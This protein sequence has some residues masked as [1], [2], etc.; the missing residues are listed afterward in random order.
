MEREEGMVVDGEGRE[1]ERKWR[2]SAKEKPTEEVMEGLPTEIRAQFERPIDVENM[3]EEGFGFAMPMRRR[4]E[5][6]AEGGSGDAGAAGAGGRAIGATATAITG[7]AEE[8][9]CAGSRTK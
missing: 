5:E 3:E 9:N 7:N 4:E 2:A 1:K 8:I 6:S